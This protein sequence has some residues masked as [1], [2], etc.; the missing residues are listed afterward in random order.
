MNKNNSFLRIVERRT[1]QR[2]CPTILECP[3]NDEALDLCD[4]VDKADSRGK[5]KLGVSR[6]LFTELVGAACDVPVR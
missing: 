6:T 3:N 5:E 2:V 4:L 1:A